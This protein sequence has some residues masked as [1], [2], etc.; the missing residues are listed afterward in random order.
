MTRVTGPWSSLSYVKKPYPYPQRGCSLR[1]I[2]LLDSS[3]DVVCY[4]RFGFGCGPYVT[5]LAL[6]PLLEKYLSVTQFRDLKKKLRNYF[7]FVFS[8]FVLQP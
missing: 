1:S 7:G 5:F 4:W 3:L 8:A 2:N 6:I